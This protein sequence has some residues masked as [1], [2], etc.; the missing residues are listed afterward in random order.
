MRALIAL[1]RA[2]W[3]LGSHALSDVFMP[4]ASS[5]LQRTFTATQRA[6]CDAETAA[7]LLELT[8][9]LDV[10]PSVERVNAPTLVLH[11]RH[12]RAIPY[13]Q[14]RELASRLPGAK[15]VTLDGNIHVPW[16]GDVEAI[17]D[18][19]VA[20]AGLDNL[21][22]AANASAAELRREGEVWA[23]R[24]AG[25]NA[26]VKDTKGVMDLARLLAHPGEAVHVLELATGARPA[27]GTGAEP[28]LDRK[29][30]QSYRR[31]LAELEDAVNEETRAVRRAE[32]E[33]E[34]AALL[35]RL[36]ADTGLGGRARKLNDPVER[37]RKAVAARI[38]DAIRRIAKVHPELGM[39]LNGS[40]ATGLC[41]VYRPRDAANWR[42]SPQH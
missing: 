12:D 3:G 24:F 18:A 11:R 42:I 35:R 9:A 20:F 39:H 21:P 32:L 14:G 26:L 22:A 5:E 28:T 37:A 27:R 41:C 4:G 2:H 16:G 7:Q 36:V 31:R 8:Y 15:L 17:L 13:A 1:V 40:V 6:G 19:V 33:K 10:T 23:L 34:R 30:V 25:R 38:R 29:A